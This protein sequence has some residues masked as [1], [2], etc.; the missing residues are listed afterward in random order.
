MEGTGSCPL[1]GRVGSCPSGRSA[2]SGNVIIG[3]VSQLCA[4]EDFKQSVW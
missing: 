2:M 3:H 4:Q 1:M